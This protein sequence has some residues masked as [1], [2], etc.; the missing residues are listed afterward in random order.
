M[1]SVKLVC[2][3]ITNNEMKNVLFID[4]KTKWNP[5]KSPALG[6]QYYTG[7]IYSRPV[8]GHLFGMRS[9]ILCVTLCRSYD[10]SEVD[11]CNWKHRT[12][13]IR[14]H[15]SFSP[16]ASLIVDLWSQSRDSSSKHHLIRWNTFKTR[17]GRA[18][19]DIYTSGCTLRLYLVSASKPCYLKNQRK[20][21]LLY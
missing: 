21:S 15:G 19:W 1:S 18:L 5:A 12:R 17:L 14:R 9:S 6:T 8:T 4:I 20:V 2:T 10:S 16:L 11:G 3:V 13:G 7:W